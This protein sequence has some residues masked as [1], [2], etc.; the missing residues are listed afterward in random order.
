MEES[1][2][3]CLTGS[4]MLSRNEDGSSPEEYLIKSVIGEGGSTVCYEAVRMLKDGTAETGK[5]KEFYPVDSVVG[6]HAWY[7]SLE[8][9]PNGQLVPGAGTVRKFDEM[10]K[11]YLSTYKLLK[12]VMVDNPVNEILKG[13][14]QQGEILYGCME[15]ESTTVSKSPFAF[16][17]KK[18][19]KKAADALIDV[20]FRK[21]TVYIWSPGVPGKGFDLYLKEIRKN[22]EKK[23]ED[24]LRIILSVMDVL[25]DCVKALH[26]AGLMH[27]DI[28]PSNFLL[29]YNSDFE[30]RPNTISL[31]DINTLCSVESEYLRVSGTKG[32][33]APEVAK[34]K[35]D[36]R[37]D[38][39]SIGATLFNAIVITEDIPDG[40]YRDLYYSNISQLVKHSA[41][42]L[43]SETNSDVALMSKLCKILQKCL[44]KDPRKRYQ[45]C[46]ELKLDLKKTIDRL[47][48][49]LKA[50][51]KKSPEGL[52]EPT[53]VIQKLLYEHPLY[54]TIKEKAE[55]INV[56]VIG[57]GTYSQ[58]FIDICLQSGQ[59]SGVNLNIVAVS[60]KPEEDK[61][62]YLCF[63]PAISKFVNIN[64]SM[65]GNEA[66]AYATVDFKGVWEISPDV[67][68]YLQ[69]TNKMSQVNH[70]IIQSLIL[71]SL[72]A[73]K[74]YDYVFVALG[75][76]AL[77]KSIATAISK[78]IGHACPVCY[79]SPTK[80][81]PRKSDI[82]NRLYPV[83]V[84]VPVDVA[85]IDQRLG[86]MA[87][88]THI[89]WKDSMNIDVT[90]E[91]KKFFEGKSEKE[92]YNRTAS[93][94]FALSV[95]YKLYSVQIE[96]S[97]L[98]EAAQMFSKQVLE[99][100]FTEPE[101][102]A[103]FD[104]LVD[105][106]HR[107]W[108]I[109]RAVDG[110]D[111]PRD[112]KGNLLL[113]DCV[114]RGSV[115]DPVNRTHPCMVRGS[116]SSPL[117]DPK[118]LEG[119]HSLW[120]TG[121]I[122]SRL[123]DLDRM[124][125]ELHRCFRSHAEKLKKENL[126]QNPDLLFIQNLIPA[127]C[128]EVERS[129]KQFQFALKN[130]I[131]GVESYSRQYEVYQDAFKKSLSVLSNEI[132]A[133]IEERLAVIEHAFFPVVE[134]NLYRNYKANDEVLIKKIPFILTYHYMPAIAIAFED[135][136]Y[137][138]GS[139]E[140]VFANVASATV[141]S[142][143]SIRFLYC[144]NKSSDVD[145]LIRKLDAILNYFGK[146]N[147]HSGVEIVI[148]CLSEVSNKEREKL[149]RSLTKLHDSYT[150]GNGNA[151]FEKD[152]IYDVEN[153][154]QA[155]LRFVEYLKEFPV[156]LYDG[157]NPL[158]PSAY[159]NSLFI[160]QITELNVPYF[161]FD[162]RSKEF[163][164]RIHCE[165]LKYVKDG[166]F[167]R[168]SDIFALMNASDT[169]FNL[170]EFADDYEEL[171]RIY[172]GKYEDAKGKTVGFEYGV[173]N[174][175]DMCICL[176]EYESNEQKKPLAKMTISTSGV[177]SFKILTYFLP[178]FCFSTIKML[179]QKLV[180]YGIAEKESSIMTHTSD[181]CKLELKVDGK[182][183]QA[184]NAVF[185]NPQILMPYYGVE[186][187]KY[188]KNNSEYVEIRYNNLTVTDIN[189]DKENKGAHKYALGVLKQLEK[190][191]FIRQL[192][193]NETDPR[194]ISF[195]YS[196]PRIKK[197]LT[198]AGEILEVYAYYDVL[199]TG[200]F[201]DVACGYE[202]RWEAGG[203]KNEL[204]LVLTKGF[205]SII[206]ECKAVK[207]LQLDYYHKLH[208]IA[209]QF[210]IGTTKVLLGNT[211]IHSNAAINELNTMQRSRGKQLY[212]KTISNKDQ[213]INIGKTLKN[214]MENAN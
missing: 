77:S 197:L 126:F 41:L 134:S 193:Q 125:I 13:Y 57:A 16:W 165:Y 54:E 116:E 102:K 83:R 86:E 212:I 200:Y 164:K 117:S 205:R 101:A 111:A 139:N 177:A 170:P 45:S 167:I 12:K 181:T 199:K 25:T 151:W 210:G 26:T 65:T 191:H 138:N 99:A 87:F 168:I 131:N 18:S 90:S 8:R 17:K 163:S 82:Q 140:A 43:A 42:F 76:G 98:L 47:D 152:I 174:W 118:Y 206:V 135:G 79:V 94:A 36:N 136:K 51:V 52:S 198:S 153:Y 160:G 37:S 104:R 159:D 29:Q 5:L 97:D 28:K 60:D 49:M 203:V 61:E 32:F 72:E 146:R 73:Q 145:L 59:M 112:D 84:N 156:D 96:C 85:S 23:S 113:E 119:N 71:Q 27:M 92:K 58:K 183:E 70:E 53:I 55:D 2:R 121:E 40:L 44:D 74:E 7:Y 150:E 14:I 31:F 48:T 172:T 107:R 148:A 127:D 144:F 192:K 4:I 19:E 24:K 6:N 22:P 1:G 33:C 78:E 66:N 109:E 169:R 162:W 176:G 35:A 110:W 190:S 100:R 69:F 62:S 103:K 207:Q 128:D 114:I 88:N 21:P 132:R 209:D 137:Q 214:L 147:V 149:Q 141:L 91:R 196:S 130:I 46:S 122:D 123:D 142:P 63:R 34:G 173:K 179:V 30:I 50:S 75:N 213:I 180:E 93:L 105:L 211:Y 3:K 201:D 129:F 202:F 166:S 11:D 38:I 143:E 178:D 67:S 81:P 204:D 175:N 158:F 171:W 195:V 15:Q 182:Y 80:A 120:D 9:L 10:C 208:S 95:K 39:Y 64:G 188:T 157:S 154:T 106:E 108:L 155:G 194:L 161:E 115:K 187:Y 184:L 133:K 124:S 56:L 68:A 89:S 186:I 185:F 20:N 189:F